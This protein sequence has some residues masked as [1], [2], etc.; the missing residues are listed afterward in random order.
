[1]NNVGTIEIVALRCKTELDDLPPRM[2]PDRTRQTKP[3]KAKPAKH[4]SPA[5]S[6]K[7]ESAIG[8]MAGLFDGVCDNMNL[9]GGGDEIPTR[10]HGFVESQ[11][12]PDM[13]WDPI[14]GEWRPA[15]DQISHA[16]SR[17][18][19]LKNVRFASGSPELIG[20]QQQADSSE[21]IGGGDGPTGF[22][23]R[24]DGRGRDDMRGDK[25]LGQ[26]GT[27]KERYKQYLRET[28]T[29][30]SDPPVFA[31][32]EFYEKFGKPNFKVGKTMPNIQQPQPQQDNKLGDRE[33]LIAMMAGRHIYEPGPLGDKQFARDMEAQKTYMRWFEEMN[34]NANL[35]SAWGDLERLEEQF[36]K[37]RNLNAGMRHEEPSGPSPVQGRKTG[38][39][40]WT[41]EQIED[42]KQGKIVGAPLQT[43]QPA[44]GWADGPH[45]WAPEPNNHSGYHMG[46]QEVGA[47]AM[48]PGQ[49]WYPNTYGPQMNNQGGNNIGY[50]PMS[51]G[52]YMPYQHIPPDFQV[53]MYGPNMPMYGNQPPFNPMQ[54]YYMNQGPGDNFAGPFN[55]PQYGAPQG[56]RLSAQNQGQN[57]WGDKKPSG[58]NVQSNGGWAACDNNNNNNNNQQVGDDNDWAN[59][60][61]AND[62]HGSW[63]KSGSKRSTHSHTSNKDD[64]NGAWQNFGN[65][66]KQSSGWKND[67]KAPSEHNSG[68]W[69]SKSQHSKA[70]SIAWGANGGTSRK[71]SAGETAKADENPKAYIKPYWA[72]WNKPPSSSETPHAEPQKCAEP[73][74]AYTYPASPLPVVP[75]GKV[76]DAS[77]GIQTGKG[78]DYSH[79]CRKPIYIDTME[80]PYAVFS[81]KYRSKD[82]LEKILKRNIDDVDVKKI[83]EQA[84]REMWANL[85]KHKLIEELM[86]K[87][88]PPY[89]GLEGSAAGSQKPATGW[90]SDNGK[91][92][93]GNGGWGSGSVK[94]GGGNG[95]WSQSGGN[96]GHHSN[97]GWGGQGSIR[98]SAAGNP[99]WGGG[100]A[101]AGKDGWGGGN[102]GADNALWGIGSVRAG[103]AGWGGENT[104]GDNGWGQNDGNSREWKDG[105][106]QTDKTSNGGKEE[107]SVWS[108]VKGPGNNITTPGGYKWNHPDHRPDPN[109]PPSPIHGGFVHP[110]WARLKD[111]KKPEGGKD[112]G[113]VWSSVKGPGNNITTPGG[114]KW[115]HPDHRPD[116]NAP[117]SPMPNRGGQAQAYS[118]WSNRGS[119]HNPAHDWRRVFPHD[120]QG[121][122]GAFN[123]GGGNIGG[124]NGPTAPA[125]FVPDVFT[126]GFKKHESDEAAKKRAK[127]EAFARE[128]NGTTIFDTAGVGGRT[129]PEHFGGPQGAGLCDTGTYFK[130]GGQGYD[131]RAADAAIGFGW[132]NAGGA[133]AAPLGGR[134]KTQINYNRRT[135]EEA[136]KLPKRKWTAE[137]E[138]FWG[139]GD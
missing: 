102:R 125:P 84:D 5:P 58:Q 94:S 106:D 27:P 24:W 89:K 26:T 82:V 134:A 93:G 32:K 47:G 136:A 63:K 43:L 62:Q 67:N 29:E 19:V 83:K 110:G 128:F 48:N 137:D 25:Y 65:Q 34:P 54:G 122:G 35:K 74:D 42:I 95:G 1:M 37:M 96:G 51:G 73:R 99:G 22:F 69:D 39:L 97:G 2:L 72:N 85:P 130:P 103:S 119:T 88:R 16:D 20:R 135:S 40:L 4:T 18:P 23:N 53:P 129:T 45:G 11:S 115:N 33:R 91:S 59:T 107:G 133:N 131:Q 127:D 38:P 77:H 61:A 71:S 120:V 118:G 100:S 55:G 9:D 139:S 105:W 70:G 101:G 126:G 124:W 109:A 68:G 114:Y 90:G 92:A 108:S 117:P 57:Q 78:A 12:P 98:N 28:G 132:G 44:Q 60:G 56:Q 41:K 112:D 81:L 30:V 7:A 8:G 6:A 111:N 13:E 104:G 3:D 121:N 10:P 49:P 52:Y 14:L 64:K 66:S 31:T 50:P 138:L 17:P 15:W 76:K 116:P 86:A 75:C 21:T 87:R 46:M 79:K 80:S 36:K 113:S 123:N